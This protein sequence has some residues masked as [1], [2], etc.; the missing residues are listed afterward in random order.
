MLMF[1]GKSLVGKILNK[2]SLIMLSINLD[3][4]QARDRAIIVRVT[5]TAFLQ[6]GVMKDFNQNSGRIL[7]SKLK[8]KNKARG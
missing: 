7:F 4:G 2:L 1:T 5:R 8:V 3:I 6:T